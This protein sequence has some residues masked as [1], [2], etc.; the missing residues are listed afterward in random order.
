MVF[1]HGRGHHG[2]M[3]LLVLLMKRFFD[4]LMSI[5]G[6]LVLA[7]PA[8]IL[9]VKLHREFGGAVFFVQVR[10]G[11][12]GRPFKM[13]KFRTMTNECDSNGELLP[14]AMRLVSFGRWLRA[15]SI[16]ELPELWNVL[17]GDMSLV[18]P[19]PLLLDYLP[20]YT[21]EQARRHKV[22]PGITGWAQVNG[23][24]SITWEE[25]FEFDVWYVE[26]RSIWLDLKI[27]WMTVGR[28]VARDGINSADEAT[29]PRFIG[30]SKVGDRQL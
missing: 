19:R 12:N 26:N 16:D 20:L 29:M 25:K 13:F 5:L 17:K 28:V 10:A 3:V 15:T 4:V 6:L 1:G 14:D 24:N 18:G 7:L 21:S 11:L 27:L 30:S 23:R 8:I 9:I 22:R 2:C